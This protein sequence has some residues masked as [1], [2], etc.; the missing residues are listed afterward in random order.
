MSAR[1]YQETRLSVIWSKTS[2]INEQHKQQSLHQSEACC[3]LK[4][5]S[6]FLK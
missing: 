1:N 3:L 4:T 6:L 2:D 5:D